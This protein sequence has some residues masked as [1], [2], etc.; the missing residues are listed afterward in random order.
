MHLADRKIVEVERK[1]GRHIGVRGLL[2]RQHD[3]QPD[4]HAACILGAAVSRL[5]H[6]RTAAC[7]NDVLP[8]ALGK[9]A[10]SDDPGEVAGF[11]VVSGQISE[12]LGACFVLVLGVRDT[13]TAEEHNG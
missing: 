1:I 8:F 10:F 3:V 4:G 12:R 6:T 5:H 2:V 11:V 7:D 13:R 9:G